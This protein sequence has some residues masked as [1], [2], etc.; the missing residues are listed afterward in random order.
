MG[1][2]GT[3]SVVHMYLQ[4]WRVPKPLVPG[5]LAF[6][7]NPPGNPPF[8]AVA[9]ACREAGATMDRFRKQPG[10]IGF[11]FDFKVRPH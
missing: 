9:L 5:A 6:P 3:H 7:Q 11:V 1:A 10:R 4:P 2:T 8:P